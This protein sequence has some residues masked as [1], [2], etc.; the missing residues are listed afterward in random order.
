MS[1]LSRIDCHG[2]E[3]TMAE[4]EGSWSH[5]IHSGEAVANVTAQL[6]VFFYSIG[7]PAHG[8][9]LPT[10]MS[11]DCHIDSVNHHSYSNDSVLEGLS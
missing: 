9:M 3:V 10:G 11:R 7:I 4:T 8:K 5:D 2:K 1:S 6:T